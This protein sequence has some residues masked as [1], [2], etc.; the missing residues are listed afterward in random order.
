MLLLSTLSLFL[1]NVLHH[2]F[3]RKDFIFELFVSNLVLFSQILKYV[4]V[5]HKG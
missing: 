4:D 1:S 3:I 5:K 2:N